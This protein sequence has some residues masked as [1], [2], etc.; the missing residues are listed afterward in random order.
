MSVESGEQ[1]LEKVSKTA[2]LNPLLSVWSRKD[3][4]ST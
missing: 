4:V 1:N 2:L 3:A